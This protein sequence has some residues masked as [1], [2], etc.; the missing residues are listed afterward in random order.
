MPK[1]STCPFG[2]VDFFSYGLEPAKGSSVKKQPS[3]LFLARSCE[4]PAT[5]SKDA[6]AVSGRSSPVPATT[7]SQASYRLRRIFYV[8]NSRCAHFAAP[9]SRSQSILLAFA[10]TRGN[11]VFTCENAAPSVGLP[12]LFRKKRR[13]AH[14]LGCKRP[15]DG[16]LSLFH[17]LRDAVRLRADRSIFLVMGLEPAKG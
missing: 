16:S 3:G 14:L 7:S 9:P 5:S 2:Q 15:R 10:L 4:E 11:E 12:L 6:N 13:S 8:K 1:K 17:F